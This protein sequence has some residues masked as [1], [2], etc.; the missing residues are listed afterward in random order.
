V[1]QAEA[2]GAL[3]FADCAT[4]VWRTIV[5]RIDGIAAPRLSPDFSSIAF[6]A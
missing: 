3:A 4:G 5:E 2:G 1:V 6:L